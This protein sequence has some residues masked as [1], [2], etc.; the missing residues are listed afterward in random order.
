MYRIGMVLQAR[1]DSSRLPGKALLYFQNKTILEHCFKPMIKVDFSSHKVIPIIATT[2]REVDDLICEIS[3]RNNIE[4]YR[5]AT[6]NVFQRYYS[7]LKNH[8]LEIVVRLTADNPFISPA[9]I[10]E[11]IELMLSNMDKPSIVTTRGTGLPV[12]LDV[13]CFN[14]AAMEFTKKNIISKYDKEHV[15]SFMLKNKKISK[16]KFITNAYELLLKTTSHSYTIDNPQD[17]LSI[18]KKQ[19]K[20]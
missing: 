3:D 20:L 7:V 16:V 9:A 1:M 13:E 12:G 6:E 2:K 5:G 11:A 14:R 18:T 4:V 17:Y 19:N 15:T 8:K 10:S